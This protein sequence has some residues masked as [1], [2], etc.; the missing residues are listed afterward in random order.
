[1]SGETC[2]EL[3]RYWVGLCD[4]RD[5]PTC[6]EFSLMD[7]YKIAP[8]LI[9]LDVVP[10]EDRSIRHLYRFVGT[11]VVEYRRKRG[12]IDA[13][14]TGQFVD[15]ASRH[16][17][18]DSI[19]D[20]YVQCTKDATPLLTYGM[21]MTD[22]KVDLHERLALPLGDGKGA[23]QKLAVCVYRPKDL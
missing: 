6:D 20:S 10:G 5:M 3:Y 22:T 13:D 15:E 18:P 4:G 12:M 17:V 9:V 11:K 14:Y 8:Y 7:V 2:L 1:M 21:F 19:V 16:Y 23:V